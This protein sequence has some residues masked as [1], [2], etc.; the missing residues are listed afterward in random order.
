MSDM[1]GRER[2]SM[3]RTRD[4]YA[5]LGSRRWTALVG[6]N[7]TERIGDREVNDMAG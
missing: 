6:G 2:V 4:E 3:N 7:P 1:E 5:V